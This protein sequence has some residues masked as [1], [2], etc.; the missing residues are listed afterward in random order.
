M[1][2]RKPVD[3][4][5]DLVSTLRP[6]Q[7]LMGLDVGSKTIGVANADLGRMIATPL[8]IIRR[9]KFKIDMAELREIIAANDVGGLVIGLPLNMDGSE[10]PRCQSIR[11][12]ADN[13][14]GEIDIPLAF[15]DERLSTAIAERALLEADMSRKRR[16][17]VID[18]MA[19]A[20]ILQG[21]L[22]RLANS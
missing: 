14:L 22:D 11:Q 13:L 6:G 8:L 3:N 21:A 18:K 19:A 1:N 5:R 7:R 12:F 10:G 20:I 4:L 2:H 16:S 9:R 17:E 15:W